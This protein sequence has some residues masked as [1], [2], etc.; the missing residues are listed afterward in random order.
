MCCGD[1][2]STLSDKGKKDKPWDKQKQ[3]FILENKF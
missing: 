2:S 3:I 1:F